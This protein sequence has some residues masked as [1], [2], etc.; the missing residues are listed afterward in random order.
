[1]TPERYRRLNALADAALPMPPERRAAFLREA[2]GSDHEL[3][4]QTEAMLKGESGAADFLNKPLL[5]E[6][7]G[8][9]ANSA[10]WRAAAFGT[11]K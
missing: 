8:D 1:V 2:C 5:E 9:M 6:L 3:R 4:E 11:M 7:A 10:I